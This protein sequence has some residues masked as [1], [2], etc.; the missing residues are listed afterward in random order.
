MAVFGNSLVL[1]LIG[2]VKK[3]RTLTDIYIISLATSDLLIATLNMPFQLYYVVA[4]DW[5]ATGDFGLFLCKLTTYI[6]GVAVAAS[7][8]TLLF[9]AID[10][11]DH[12]YW[13]FLKIH[14]VCFPNPYL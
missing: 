1:G 9:I 13:S 10:R 12:H 5:M 11:Y 2:V 14:N 6:E 4:N 3:I 8:L 7:I